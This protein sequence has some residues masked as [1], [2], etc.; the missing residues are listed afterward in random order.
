M[1]DEAKLAVEIAEKVIAHLHTLDGLNPC[2]RLAPEDHLRDLQRDVAS[3]VAGLLPTKPEVVDGE[4][5]ERHREAAASAMFPAMSPNSYMARWVVTGEM[6][7]EPNYSGPVV[8]VAQAIAAAESRG[9]AA[10]RAS[11]IPVAGVAVY[12][13]LFAALEKLADA[14]ESRS[15]CLKGEVARGIA[16]RQSEESKLSRAEVLDSCS[17]QIRRLLP[18]APADT[19]PAKDPTQVQ[20]SVNGHVF[21]GSLESVDHFGNCNR[22][23]L[24][25]R[26]RYTQRCPINTKGE[27]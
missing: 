26:A 11:V 24:Q 2:L 27:S 4:E 6:D 21:G 12:G 17:E 15:S 9:F 13:D 10:G 3:I 7:G 19:E 22:C 8:R 14:W 5:T 18:P 25:F 20:H 1:A 16:I 23:G